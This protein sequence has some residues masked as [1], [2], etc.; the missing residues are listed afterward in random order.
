MDKKDN[1][2]RKGIL[3]Q[4][5]VSGLHARHL[6]TSG[7]STNN[8]KDT[9]K[10]RKNT[11]N[12]A[13]NLTPANGENIED[14]YRKNYT[15]LLVCFLSCILVFNCTVM[16]IL[17]SLGNVPDSMNHFLDLL[18]DICVVISLMVIF[19]YLS[20]FSNETLAFN[21]DNAA[22]CV[23]G[24]VGNL[25]IAL[26]IQLIE[27]T[28]LSYIN[29]FGNTVYMTAFIVMLLKYELAKVRDAERQDE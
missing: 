29:L 4:S 1:K 17:I 2:L 10:C 24:G 14:F 13:Q 19:A 25:L 22:T 15:F 3:R 20:A 8:T 5:S 21:Y 11:T 7:T 18:L 16:H 28:G 26:E 9:T 12:G 6:S 27:D 23:I